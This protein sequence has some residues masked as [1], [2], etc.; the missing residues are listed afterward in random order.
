MIYAPSED[1]YLMCKALEKNV[2]NK[3]SKILEVGVGSGYVLEFLKK[4]G[5]QNAL[6][7]DINP[8][9]V[10]FCKKRKLKV[11]RSDLFSR[12]KDKF[13]IIIFNPPYLPEDKRE[14]KNSKLSTTGG[15]YG[16]EVINRFLSE[17]KI[18]LKKGGKIFLVTSSLTKRIDWKGYKKRKVGEK[19]LF[20]EKLNVWELSIL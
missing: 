12:V 18:H 16:S 15:K 11:I 10:E 2:P 6:G 14:D 13:G 7:I 9:A 8:K 20:F 19:K 3:S 5:F 1:T 4:R 17:A